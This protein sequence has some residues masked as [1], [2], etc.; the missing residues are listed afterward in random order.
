MGREPIFRTCRPRAY[1]RSSLR[2]IALMG[3]IAMLLSAC[4]AWYPMS[5]ES[6]AVPDK[7]RVTTVS[8]ERVELRDA[9]LVGDSAVATMRSGPEIVGG[10][11][12]DDERGRGLVEA[13]NPPLHSAGRHSAL[14]GRPDRCRAKYP[15]GRGANRRNPTWIRLC[16][17]CWNCMRGTPLDRTATPIVRR[18][19]YPMGTRLGRIVPLYSCRT[20]GRSK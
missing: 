5:L 18:W 20:G 9:R 10:R 1:T 8:L 15:V 11:M 7:V 12:M 6:R 19:P 2:T 14:G 3:L 13:R 4:T 17:C 16:L